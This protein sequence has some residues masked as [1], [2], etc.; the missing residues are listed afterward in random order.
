MRICVLASGSKCNC[1]YLETD[2][3][4]ILIDFGTTLKYTK[5][6]LFEIGVDIKD[7]DYVFITHSHG[8]HT[9]GLEAFTRKYDVKVF[10]TEKIYNELGI[11]IPNFELLEDIINIDSL[12]IDFVRLSHDVDEV[13]G[14]IFKE[15]NRKLVYITD[16]GY[17]NRKLYKKL[18]DS[19]C[20]AIESNH[21]VEMLMNGRYQYFT[22]IRIVGDRG[23]LSNDKSSEFISEVMGD[24][25]ENV[26]L[27]H[28]SEENNTV[29][30]AR[31]SFVSKLKKDTNLHISKGKERTDVINV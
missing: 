17:I 26:I 8:D 5:E 6:K 31:N 10:L 14:Y 4:K 28:L 27:L 25:T 20:Y 3:K 16:T 19:N 11:N 2:N 29:E 23:H 18:S 15:N 1:S 12:E 24:N 21:D 9:A 7:I 13:L 22:K 30:L